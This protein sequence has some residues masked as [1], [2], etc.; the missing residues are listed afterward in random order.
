MKDIVKSAGDSRFLK[1]LELIQG[2]DDIGHRF[3]TVN[4]MYQP[5][6][7]VTQG[8]WE[9]WRILYAGW[10]DL[11]LDFMS[12][13]EHNCEFHPLAK[14]GIYIQDFPRFIKN[15]FPIPPGGRSD[16]MVRCNNPK[17]ISF[18]AM[19][20]PVITLAVQPPEGKDDA[21]VPQ[22]LNP[23][24]PVA[25]LLYLQSLKD[26]TVTPGCSCETTM[27]GYDESGRING[28]VW[29][30]G[31]RF[32]HTS[33]LGA[34]VERALKGMHEHSYHQHV[35][36]YQLVGGFED[37]K[38]FRKGDWHDVF[39]DQSEQETVVMRYRATKFP[40]KMMVHCHNTQHADRGMLAKEYVRNVTEGEC[41]CNTFEAVYGRGIAD[42]Y[43]IPQVSDYNPKVTPN[44]S[45]ANGMQ[46]G[47]IIIL[48]AIVSSSAI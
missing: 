27:D 10:L 22:P 25:L 23:W 42:N 43:L 29:K 35:Y 3:I 28:K 40:G 16:V 18:Q 19:Y 5:T 41:T 1:S 37:R 6:M 45:C 7:T 36:P 26:T 14:D 30:S 38:Y 13:D 15:K 12:E 24:T 17:N 11:P 48:V 9:R 21:L 20:R 39:L 44:K 46:N 47:F 33:F 31:N 2:G 34:V 32:M 4:D 8:V